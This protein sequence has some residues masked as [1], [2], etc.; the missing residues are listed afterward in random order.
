MAEMPEVDGIRS[1]FLEQSIFSG[2]RRPEPLDLQEENI[3]AMKMWHVLFM[4][5]LKLLQFAPVSHSKTIVEDVAQ[6]KVVCI[7]QAIKLAEPSLP[8][9]CPHW[10]VLGL[11]EPNSCPGLRARTRG[12]LW[13]SMDRVLNSTHFWCYLKSK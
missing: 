7:G 5:C 6:E 4:Q 13:N 9:S 12:H 8:P 10:Q 1:T 11:G 3:F 2:G